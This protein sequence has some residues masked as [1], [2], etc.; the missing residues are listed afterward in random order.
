MKIQ[1]ARKF[2]TSFLT[3]LLI[4]CLLLSGT[5][6]PASAESSD[7]VLTFE[8]L[9]VN[10]MEPKALEGLY[11]HC[12]FGQGMWNIVNSAQNGKELYAN[13]LSEDQ[14]VCKIAIP[15]NSIFTGFKARGNNDVH[16]QVVSGVDQKS[17]TLSET[18]EEYKT[19]FQTPCEAVYI[20]IS[21]AGGASSAKFDDITL[22]PSAPAA[23][24]DLADAKEPGQ[25]VNYNLSYGKGVVSGSNDKSFG[26]SG[27]I[28]DNDAATSWTPGENESAVIDYGKKYQFSEFLLEYND[29]T[30]PK[31]YRIFISDDKDTWTELVDRSSGSDTGAVQREEVTAAGR[32]LKIE[33]TQAPA[34]L[35]EFKAYG[36][37]AHR[38]KRKIMVIVPHP[39]D[40]MRMCGGII[41]DAV[42]KGDEVKVVI[43]GNGDYK[44]PDE[45][46]KRIAESIAALNN[47][48][49]KTSDIIF[50]GYADNGGLIGSNGQEPDDSHIYQ[51]YTASDENAVILSRED[52]S[53]TYGLDTGKQDYH[54]E[55]TGEHADY[56]RKNFIED[57]M[58]A[59][60]AFRP[61]DIYSTSLYD[62]HTDHAY[63]N[64]FVREAILTLQKQD[65]FF[66]PTLREGIIHS[67]AGDSNLDG[68][69]RWPENNSDASVAFTKPNL[70]EEATTLDWNK[71]VSVTVPYQMRQPAPFRYSLKDQSLN[72]YTTQY[73]DLFFAAFSKYDEVFWEK[74]FT[75]LTYSASVQVNASS[76]QDKA[77]RVLD[78]IASGY[79]P[80]MEKL[81]FTASA[82]KKRDGFPDAEWVADGP[83]DWVEL[84]WSTPQKVQKIVIYDRPDT[85]QNITSGKLTFDDGTTK[86]VGA[87][88]E[89]GR[90]YELILETEKEMQSLK[91]EI[92]GVSNGT[93]NPG[94]AEIEVFGSSNQ[95]KEYLKNLISTAKAIKN[96]NSEYT[97]ESY[98]DL[99]AAII[100]AEM[101]LNSSGDAAALR[102]A[103]QE[104]QAAIDGLKKADHNNSGGNNFNPI[105]PDPESGKGKTETTTQ[106]LP[107][108]GTIIETVIKTDSNGNVTEGITNVTAGITS[109]NIEK[110]AARFNIILPEQ[111]LLHAVEDGSSILNILLPAEELMVQLNSGKGTLIDVSVTIPDSIMNHEALSIENIELPKEVLEAAKKNG[112][113]VQITF[114]NEQGQKYF[115]W[116]FEAKALKKAGKI[117]DINLALA[118]HP[119][120]EDESM[121]KLIDKKNK[122]KS[123]ILSFQHDGKLP[124]NTKVTLYLGDHN[125]W[126]PGK[127]GYLYYHDENK[128]KL[129]E[130]NKNKYKIDKKKE[131][132][133]QI[134]SCS[135]YVL[136]PYVP[137]GKNVVKLFDEI[138]VKKTLTLK[139]GKSASLKVT[140]GLNADL[141]KKFTTS[142]K[143][144]ATVSKNGKINAKKPGTT[145]ITTKITINGKTKLFK[146]KVS[147]K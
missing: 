138:S 36:T 57:L 128:N 25:V 118:L 120:N 72:L 4:I 23:P 85:D 41:R 1:E 84:M 121:A 94:L 68:G 125:G 59:I 10:D 102:A 107:E 88:P 90:P 56:T 16:I 103:A 96:D 74:S 40:E 126:K 108:S 43:S 6:V 14:Q 116:K 99:K 140:N 70:L 65:Y 82:S 130:Q 69:Q 11:G 92:T 46:K 27:Y 64:L 105:I 78:G 45:G 136:L 100:K 47:I 61:T 145:V 31:Q 39:G 86:E 115:S 2:G 26:S 12:N 32:F 89:N 60:K 55:Y 117:K 147:V 134:N 81:D 146:T 75:S 97:T 71:R 34:S 19:D 38:E 17:F 48:G 142:N 129:V 123:L 62:M 37:E 54:F 7:V 20:I 124:E 42:M 50:M 109:T 53:Q 143:A 122:G 28:T 119:D 8:D 131:I 80:A 77:N 35:T 133:I 9:S 51:M 58:H 114:V 5:S 83:G 95:E 18:K 79:I 24:E 52:N 112:T 44:G 73:Q 29:P 66:T 98:T 49:V 21:S 111:E 101:I 30:N 110:K 87:L 113:D 93:T 127:T 15:E 104:L 106:T 63:L 91:F 139:K 144:V 141:V 137:T 13:D 22:T 132:T 135:D 3:Y 33:F 67:V 76:N